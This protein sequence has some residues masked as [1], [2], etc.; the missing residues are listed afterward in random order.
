MK[1]NQ[2]NSYP[3]YPPKGLIDD[4]IEMNN[5]PEVYPQNNQQMNYQKDLINGEIESNPQPAVY[6]QNNNLFKEENL[7]DHSIT[8]EIRKGF[9]IKTYGIV[10][11]Q[12]LISLFFVFLSFNSS[13]REFFTSGKNA[14]FAFFNVIFLIVTIG[15]FIIFLCYRDI[16]RKVPINYILIFSFTLCMSFYLLLLSIQF[17]AS[18][19]I[20]ALILSI[21][22]TLGLTFYACTTKTNFT[23][24]GGFLFSMIL[25]LMTSFALF[26]WFGNMVFY[27]LLEIAL[28]LVHLTY[29]TQLIIGKVGAEFNIDDYCLAA[30]EFISRY[31]IF[32]YQNSKFIR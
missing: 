23:F 10:L 29:N 30:L 5:Q 16:A 14:F 26:Y 9:I 13:I 25:V 7:E 8:F 32:V 19:V 11:F 24:C 2:K 17:E 15:V 21:A 31:N 1:E 3:E 28:C 18:I 22:S 6:P 12:L 4:E 27:C 20:S